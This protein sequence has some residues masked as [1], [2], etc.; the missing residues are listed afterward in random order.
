[1]IKNMSQHCI[2]DL[3]Y[4]KVT[5]DQKRNWLLTSVYHEVKNLII[6]L[7]QVIKQNY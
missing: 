2:I 6:S 4:F 5:L 7:F 1:M 3:C